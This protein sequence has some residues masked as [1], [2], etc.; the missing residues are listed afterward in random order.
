MQLQSDL[1]KACLLEP[2]VYFINIFAYKNKGTV[3]YLILH[4]TADQA[5]RLCKI[6]F[7]FLQ[8]WE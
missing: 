4:N 3:P 6:L 2:A 8:K 5:M 1:R 7:M